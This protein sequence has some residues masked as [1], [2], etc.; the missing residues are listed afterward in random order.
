MPGAGVEFDSDVLS[1]EGAEA[2]GG[3][4][5]DLEE[6]DD[7]DLEPLRDGGLD[8]NR[9]REVGGSR[10]LMILLS[11]DDLDGRSPDDDDEF[12]SS[13]VLVDMVLVLSYGDEGVGVDGM[14]LYQ[15]SAEKP[16]PGG[17]RGWMVL[18]GMQART[19]SGR[20]TLTGE[21]IW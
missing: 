13:E 14:A 19:A 3:M 5:V 7:F 20:A 12:E 2:T 21:L 1:V 18:D 8:E 9:A 6:E 17:D 11:F 10:S 16:L 4:G 15:R